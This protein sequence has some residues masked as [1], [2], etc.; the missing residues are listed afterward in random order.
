MK[1]RNFTEPREKHNNG[2]REKAEETEVVSEPGWLF[3]NPVLSGRVRAGRDS[4]LLTSRKVSS[5]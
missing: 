5:D 3:Q 2:E 1:K 4:D